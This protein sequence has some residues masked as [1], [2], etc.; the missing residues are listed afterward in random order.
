MIV[1]AVLAAAAPALAHF[2]TPSFSG[3]PDGITGHE[4]EDWIH[5]GDGN[6][7]MDGE[8]LND[9]LHGDNHSDYGTAGPG[10]DFSSSSI[11]CDQ[12]GEQHFGGVCGG[13]GDD[14]ILS[15]GNTTTLN[16]EGG[17]DAVEGGGGDDALKGGG[18]KDRLKGVSGD[19]WLYAD[20]GTRDYTV[21]GG[22]GNNDIC[23]V[24]FG[25][26]DWI[27]CAPA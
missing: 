21:Q 24:D 4:H 8:G 3:G 5:G 16:G 20:D 1:V 12:P 18:G 23:I 9:A 14:R 2:G 17:D 19:D 25:L 6:D 10:N 11:V 13:G 22:D 26:D 15:G 27:S 7:Y